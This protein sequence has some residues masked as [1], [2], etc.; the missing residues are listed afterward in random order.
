MPVGI[1]V[2]LFRALVSPSCPLLVLT[3]VNGCRSPQ[4]LQKK[5][6]STDEHKEVIRITTQK[7]QH[8]LVSLLQNKMENQQLAAYP[9]SSEKP[10]VSLPQSAVQVVIK[11]LVHTVPNTHTHT[12]TRRV[13]KNMKTNHNI[14]SHTEKCLTQ[15]YVCV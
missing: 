2:S 14:A 12:H 7:S 11:R 4:I 6:K 15:Q 10:L 8:M 1:V 13:K 3:S 9:V 5:E